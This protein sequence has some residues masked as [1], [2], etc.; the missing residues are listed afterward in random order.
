MLQS[1]FHIQCNPLT[2]I[3][4]TIIHTPYGTS[5]LTLPLPSSHSE[6]PVNSTTINNSIRSWNGNNTNDSTV[7]TTTSATTADTTTTTTN[8]NNTVNNNTNFLIAN[9]NSDTTNNID[10][11]TLTISCTNLITL[12][13]F[14]RFIQSYPIKKTIKYTTNTLIHILEKYV[15]PPTTLPS[16][17][18]LYNLILPYCIY[19]SKIGISILEQLSTSLE[20][21]DTIKP[22]QYN[23][24]SRKIIHSSTHI[25]SSP[26]SITSSLSSNSDRL[27][28]LLSTV[29][30][31][32][33]DNNLQSSSNRTIVSNT[34]STSSSTVQTNTNTTTSY[35]PFTSS[36]TP[37][38]YEINSITKNN[39]EPFV[40]GTVSRDPFIYPNSVSS[41][42]PT[43]THHL[44]RYTKNFRIQKF[45]ILHILEQNTVFTDLLRSVRPFNFFVYPSKTN[46]TNDIYENGTGMSSSFT[47]SIN[48]II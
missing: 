19:N 2:A 36:P 46:D 47:C 31:L 3:F 21:F 18:I 17:F 25:T 48:G 29:Q 7:S 13:D 33:A 32:S 4:T 44:T 22:L 15:R 6:C 10:S 42:I 34:V 43:T 39:S 27:S 8:I 41:S 35:T 40:D 37:S 5:S 28:C 16:S 26:L 38:N 24:Q 1:P 45:I 23:N 30:P 9:N 14:R 20:Y 11:P 12:F